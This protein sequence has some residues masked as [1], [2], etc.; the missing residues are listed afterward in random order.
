MKKTFAFISVFALMTGSAFAQDAVQ[1]AAE[2]AAAEISEAPVE[3]VAAPKPNYWTNSLSVSLG[4]TNTQLDNWAAGGPNTI[5]LASAL[6]AKADYKKDLM[7][8]NNRLQLDYGFLH[9]SEKEGAIQKSNDRI[10][11]ESKWAYQTGA[12]SKLSY[13]ASYDFRSQFTD[14]PKDYTQDATTN[15]WVAG[16]PVSGFISPA[17]TNLALGIQWV[18]NA[19]FNVNIAPLTGGF[20]IVNNPVLRS[21]YGMKL[22]VA[23]DDAAYTAAVAGGDAAQIGSFYKSALFQFGAQIKANLKFVINDNFTFESQATVFTDYLSEPYFR[24]NWDNAIDWQLS[25]LI[26]LSAKLWTI[27]DPNVV[28]VAD[29]GTTTPRGWQFKEFLSFAFTYTLSSKK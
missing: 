17:Y 9:S 5:T 2:D 22:G 18:P 23:E 24:I 13:T 1:K 19:W 26:K 16:D 6:D 10:Y 11:L 20:T 3:E 28:I 25:K 4:V 29:D 15:K 12:D 7:S 14:T 27:N 21:S 8:W